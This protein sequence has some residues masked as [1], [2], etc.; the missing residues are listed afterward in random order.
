L[1]AVK[2]MFENV[3]SL[4]FLKWYCHLQIS[5]GLK[6]WRELKTCI[7]VILQLRTLMCSVSVHVNVEHC[8]HENT[9]LFVLYSNQ[10]DN[11]MRVPWSDSCAI[12]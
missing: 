3:V 10:F 1:V 2:Y 11:L 8:L 5:N 9:T 6:A 4:K 7:S 12:C